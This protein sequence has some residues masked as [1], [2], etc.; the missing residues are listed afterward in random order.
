MENLK[1]SVDTLWFFEPDS[2]LNDC[3]NVNKN[4]D[5]TNSKIG[6]EGNLKFLYVSGIQS[7]WHIRG[8]S[9]KISTFPKLSMAE[10]N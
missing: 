7:W 1:K 6:A 4:C 2:F 8:F 10:K 9:G 5:N 3:R